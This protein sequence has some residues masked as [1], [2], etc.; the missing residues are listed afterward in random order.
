MMY[1]LNIDNLRIKFVC[2]S[3]ILFMV[4]FQIFGKMLFLKYVR[5]IF[6]SKV[7]NYE[8]HLTY[9]RFSIYKK[10]IESSLEDLNHTRY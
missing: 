1:I 7:L 9:F 4:I 10:I 5:L 3:K 8:S 6:R 2:N